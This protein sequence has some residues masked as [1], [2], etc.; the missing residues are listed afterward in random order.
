MSYKVLDIYK[1][2]P[3][4]NCKDCGLSGCFPF[5]TAVYLQEAQLD[6]CPHLGENFSIMQAK[7]AES[8]DTGNGVRPPNSTQAL[9][10][11]LTVMETLDFERQATLAGF[12]YDS[13]KEEARLT[14]FGRP[15]SIS[16]TKVQALDGSDLPIWA[17]V[18]LFIH[19]IQTKGTPAKGEW[20]A[21]K[22]LPNTISKTQSFDDHLDRLC[23]HFENDLERLQQASHALGGKPEDHGSADFSY[24]FHALPHI[25]TVLLY[26]KGDED[27][28]PHASLLLDRGVLNHLDQE[29]AVFLAE[30]QVDLLIDYSKQ[31]SN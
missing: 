10:Y 14:F 8:R 24:R 21:F 1:D 6:A 30:T 9:N 5:A 26:R 19:L 12:E 17:H 23:R 7:L 20:V 18:F 13:T 3:K 28:E 15:I 16:R 25:D 29:A 22:E 2:L 31:T 27:F 11:L 4:T